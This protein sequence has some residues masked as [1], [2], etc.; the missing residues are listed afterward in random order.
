M[1]NY[2]Y[3]RKLFKILIFKTYPEI[4]EKENF[5]DFYWIFSEIIIG[6]ISIDEFDVSLNTRKKKEHIHN[7]KLQSHVI[8]FFLSVGAEERR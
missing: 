3:R 8:I 6:E 5:L 1:N 7:H 4:N 2:M